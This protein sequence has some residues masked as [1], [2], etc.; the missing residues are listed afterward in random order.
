MRRAPPGRG[1]IRRVA[2]VARASRE[3]VGA[4]VERIAQRV[5]QVDGTLLLE[6]PLHDACRSEGLRLRGHAW[7]PER[8]ASPDLLITL[9]GDGT[10]L[11]GGRAVAGRDVP[12]LGVNLGRLG[13]LTSVS[14]DEM[15]SALDRVFEGDFR[16][17]HRFTLSSR[18]TAG[19][20]PVAGPFL[21]LNDVV[22]HKSGVARVSRL[23]VRVRKDGVAEDVGSFSGDGVIVA[24]PTG[25]TAYSLSA[26][27]PVVVPSVECLLLTPVCPHTLGWRPLAVPLTH[28]ILLN[29]LDD[30]GEMVLTVDGQTIHPVGPDQDVEVQRGDVSVPLIRFEGG[31]FFSTLRRK[32]GWA[33]VP[34]PSG[35]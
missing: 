17:D 23:H 32:L 31:S 11:R 35:S 2:V 18:I 25:S 29:A 30:T 27:G 13:F 7:D 5:A 33:V 16:L 22:L 4:V 19:G 24:T 6:S 1:A 14:L 28:D 20:K 15:D 10:L 34:S 21:A 12:L 26:G 9:G 3:G 8:D